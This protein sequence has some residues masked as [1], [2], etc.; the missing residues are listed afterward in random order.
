MNRIL[1][2]THNT[3][4]YIVH[5]GTFTPYTQARARHDTL[6]NKVGITCVSNSND[7]RTEPIRKRIKDKRT[8]DK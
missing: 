6:K 4:L 5:V 1:R 7:E 3:S 2:K 8:T